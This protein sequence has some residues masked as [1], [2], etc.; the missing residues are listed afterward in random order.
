MA[1]ATRQAVATR[2]QG[3]LEVPGINPLPLFD[4][5]DPVQGRLGRQHSKRVQLIGQSNLRL[6]GDDVLQELVDAWA[7]ARFQ[8][9]VAFVI[10]TCALGEVPWCCAIVFCTRLR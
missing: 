4:A 2:P 9:A 3:F 1:A 6:E 5:R 10:A 8:D 7:M